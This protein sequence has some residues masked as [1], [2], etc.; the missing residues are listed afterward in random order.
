M[1]GIPP[2]RAV[3]PLASHPSSPRQGTERNLASGAAL[4]MIASRLPL[5]SSSPGLQTHLERGRGPGQ[6]LPNLPCTPNHPTMSSIGWLGR[7]GSFCCAPCTA[8]M[9]PGTVPC[10]HPQLVEFKC[11]EMPPAHT[12]GTGEMPPAPRC[13]PHMGSLH[14]GALETLTCWQDG[15]QGAGTGGFRG[16]E[17]FQLG[18]S[19]DQPLHYPPDLRLGC[20]TTAIPGP[21]S[22]RAQPA[23]APALPSHPLPLSLRCQPPPELRV[24]AI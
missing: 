18:P 12:E 17:S 19:Q 24:P 4:I 3:P 10:S 5:Q 16:Q 6:V 21:R 8:R 9:C 14:R 20:T 22:A 2:N 23:A 13:H 15:A 11:A 7:E 1:Q